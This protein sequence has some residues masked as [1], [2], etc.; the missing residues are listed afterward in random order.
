MAAAIASA[1]CNSTVNSPTAPSGPKS[2]IQHV[3]VLFQENRS[4]NMMFMKFPGADTSTT[5]ECK[6][7]APKGYPPVCKGGQTVKLHSI[8]LETTGVPDQGKDIQH[9]HHGF[10]VEYDGGK[11]DGFGSIFEG[12]N[13][14]GQPARTYPYA[15][16]ERH[17]VQPYWDMATRYALADHMFS[18]ATTD[19]F[20]AHQQIIAGTTR[21][22]SHESVT[23]V[24][25]NRPWGCDAY[26]SEVTDVIT[27]DG[28]VHPGAGPFPCFTQY[29]TMADV[30]DAANVSWKY[31]VESLNPNSPYFD[32]SGQ[33][34]NAYDAIK[35]VRY[36]SSDWKNIAT[37]NTKIFNDIQ[38]GTLPQVAWV[39]PQLLDSDHPASGSKTGPSWVTSVVNAVGKSQYW[40]NT[41]I[42]VMWDDWGGFYDNVPPPQLDYTSLGMRVPMIVISPFAKPHYV[43]KTQYEFGSV[44]KFIEENFGAGS[45]GSTDA[46]ANSIGDIFDF[47]Q[48]PGQFQPFAAPYSQSYFFRHRAQPSPEKI[49]EHDGGIPD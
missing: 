25:S 1:G 5:G 43:S 21:L 16:V 35:H 6:E 4:F 27:T 32:F 30:L 46:R 34:W 2:S 19:S 33:V 41:A 26:P 8:T 24:P 13:G 7:F 31:Y 48:K 18:T 49:I 14:I 42:V 10:E 47:G 17:E 23:N 15:F 45:L 39:I 22:N 29:Q 36:T 3:I 12:T 37:P 28:V 9:D 11:M 40:K 38:A 44:L 20:V